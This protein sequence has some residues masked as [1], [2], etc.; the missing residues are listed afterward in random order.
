M[1]RTKK[2]LTSLPAILTVAL[3]L[4]LGYGWDYQRNRPPQALAVLPFVFEPGNIAASLAKGNGFSSPFRQQTGPTAW[5]APVYPLILAG[6]F[7]LFGV[8]TFASFVAAAGF[9]I[10]CSTLTAVPIYFAGCR[11]GGPATATL[12]AWLWAVFPN[13]IKLPVESMW[14][15]SLAALL[16]AL[17]LWATLALAESRGEWAWYG[18]GLLWGLALMTSPALGAALPFL[19]AWLAWRSRRFGRPLLALAAAALCCVP[20]TLR[21]YRVFHTFIPLR[22]VAGLTLWMGN[23]DQSHGIWPGRLHPL[24]NAAERA[25]YVELGEI[26]Y[27]R[28]K[29]EQAL[30]FIA[31]HPWSEARAVWSHFVALWSGGSAH[32]LADL[33]QTDSWTLRGVLLFNLLA[34]TGALVGIVILFR[35]H[36]VW[37]FPLA[38][39]PTVFPLVYYFTLGQARYR[40]PIDPMLLLLSASTIMGFVRQPARARGSTS[41]SGAKQAN[42]PASRRAATP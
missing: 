19:L 17:I 33:V 22:S 42:H 31:E 20:W 4:R 14:E 15:A 39:F 36:N 38:V 11:I 34:V 40:H 26:A 8:F 5:L 30:S 35:A 29:E 28:N 27:M 25:R 18:Y 13:A 41:S 37:A 7:K 6:I 16:A 1:V 23:Y 32:P 10:F 24:G 9:N 3:C 21:N 12:S 2:I